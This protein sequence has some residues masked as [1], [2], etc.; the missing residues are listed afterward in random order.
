[1]RKTT[2]DSKKWLTRVKK[3]EKLVSCFLVNVP[4]CFQKIS[5]A[6]CLFLLVFPKAGD[7]VVI[8]SPSLF[9]SSLQS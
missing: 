2:K 6:S 5:T 8:F 1:M 3:Q 7:P 9:L 4:H